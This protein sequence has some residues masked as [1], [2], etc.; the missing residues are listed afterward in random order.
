MGLKPG[1]NPDQGLS[2]GTSPRQASRKVRSFVVPADQGG[3][4]GTAKDPPRSWRRRHPEL[5]KAGV[6]YPHPQASALDGTW[7]VSGQLLPAGSPDPEDG[8]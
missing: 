5:L 8:A 6:K 4:G 2:C 3:T 1:V 7:A